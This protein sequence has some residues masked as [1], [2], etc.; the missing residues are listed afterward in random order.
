M[1]QE[2][3][4]AKQA[5]LTLSRDPAKRPLGV[6]S[7]AGDRMLVGTLWNVGMSD[8]A[9]VNVR[10][11]L[12]GDELPR[13]GSWAR[14]QDIP[15]SDRLGIRFILPFKVEA[16]GH[17]EPR[18]DEALADSI[19][20]VNVRF[21]DDSAADRVVSYCFRFDRAPLPHRWRSRQVE[22]SAAPEI[23]QPIEN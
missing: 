2:A 17:D 7:T 4:I 13:W 14:Q 20:R 10:A 18:L 3:L 12:N 16:I 8:A 22:C 15:V 6:G 23:E 21:K 5:V 11:Y 9:L 19:V 1:E